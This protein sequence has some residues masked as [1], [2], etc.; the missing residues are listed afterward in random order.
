MHL[1]TEEPN[2]INLGR[3]G[4]P[5]EG[6]TLRSRRSGELG[7]RRHREGCTG[8]WSKLGERQEKSLWWRCRNLRDWTKGSDTELEITS[9]V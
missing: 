6:P 3:S 4:G 2:H 7:L 8:L 1:F 9:G 5:C